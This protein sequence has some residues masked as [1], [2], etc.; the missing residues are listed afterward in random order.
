MSMILNAN[1]KVSKNTQ[2]IL[3]GGWLVIFAIFWMAAVPHMSVLIPT[4]AE[5]FKAF[6]I[7][8]KQ[9]VLVQLFSSLFV[10]ISAIFFSLVLG[11]G[12]SYLSTIPLF[13]A[14][15]QAIGS[16]RVVSL[17][18]MNFLFVLA[19]SNGYW[20]KVA[21]L[22]FF[23]IVF[24]V[25]SMLQVIEN[26]PT[27]KF[28]HARTLGMGKWQILYEDVILGTL[29]DA[30]DTIRINAAMA[31]MGLTM[32]EANARSDGGIG[33]TLIELARQSNY[34][35]IF[36]VQFMILLVGLGQDKLIQFAKITTCPYT[37]GQ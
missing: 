16:A 30:F 15:V 13:K 1:A 12:L 17:T 37:K 26:I 19:T 23:V 11:L 14:P 9:G 6:M 3:V 34:A 32:V 27:A 2:S 28:N 5:V 10:S 33:I 24:L 4:P 20:L 8:W 21:T 31:W 36:A 25:N 18:G 35:G 22:S 29:P 7:T